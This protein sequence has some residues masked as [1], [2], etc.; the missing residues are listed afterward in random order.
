[1]VTLIRHLEDPIDSQKSDIVV[2][3][4]GQTDHDEMICEVDLLICKF[5][6]LQPMHTIVTPTC[7]TII[8][9]TIIAMQRIVGAIRNVVS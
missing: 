1:M 6:E 2:L 7:V 4:N 8:L 5:I 9:P 3:G